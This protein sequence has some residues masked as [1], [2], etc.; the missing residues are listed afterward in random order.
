MEGKT[1]HSR[2]CDSQ[3]TTLYALFLSYKTFVLSIH[4]I[5]KSDY[6]LVFFRAIHEDLEKSNHENM[7]GMSTYFIMAI[8]IYRTWLCGI[9]VIHDA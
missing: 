7:H 3:M 1:S 4:I 6:R 8:T 9:H 2:A 5:F